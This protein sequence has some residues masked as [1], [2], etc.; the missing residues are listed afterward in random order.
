MRIGILK[1]TA[2]PADNRVALTPMQAGMLRRQYPELEL[3]VQSSPSR[4]YSDEAYRAEGVPVVEDLST[5][6]L[7][8]GIKAPAA[9]TL[10]PGKHY[11]FFG[12]F[13]KGQTY[14]RPFL[15]KLMKQGITFSDYEYMVD[16]GGGRVCAFGWWA[17]V[18]GIY[19]TLQG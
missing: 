6:D 18:V 10:I 2:T 4:T 1:E 7:L 3:M 16:E 8:L 9:E 13:A 19:Y 11:V 12:H 14:N 5:C 15:Q 17:G